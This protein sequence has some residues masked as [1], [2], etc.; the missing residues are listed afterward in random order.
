[1]YEASPSLSFTNIHIA[2]VIPSHGFIS[3]N[4]IFVTLMVINVLG[5]GTCVTSLVAHIV[6]NIPIGF[7]LKSNL[8]A[9]FPPASSF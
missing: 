8:P 9:F 7:T 6:N 1:M 5:T 2:Q 4:Y 3:R